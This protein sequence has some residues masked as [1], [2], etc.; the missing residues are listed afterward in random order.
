[1]SYHCADSG[2]CD[3]YNMFMSLM[4]QLPSVEDGIAIHYAISGL[5]VSH[6]YSHF[7]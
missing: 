1:M 4:S 2:L 3:Y 6:L 7:I 5:C